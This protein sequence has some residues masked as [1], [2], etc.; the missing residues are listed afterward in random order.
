MAF[1]WL[2]FHVILGIEDPQGTGAWQCQETE[3]SV[4]VSIFLCLPFVAM[5]MIGSWDPHAWHI[6]YVGISSLRLQ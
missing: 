1:Q 3:K 6:W 4:T 2:F 5:R